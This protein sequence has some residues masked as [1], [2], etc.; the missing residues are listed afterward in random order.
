MCDYA[1]RISASDS[2]SDI[3]MS[4]FLLKIYLHI[5][6]YERSETSFDI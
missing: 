3:A 4:I 6:F 1:Y 5:H 2:V